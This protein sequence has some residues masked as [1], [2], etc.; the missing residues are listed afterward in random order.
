MNAPSDTRHTK[1]H[2]ELILNMRHPSKRLS[3][4][5]KRWRRA[6]VPH[7][8]NFFRSTVSVRQSAAQHFVAHRSKIVQPACQSIFHCLILACYSKL[9]ANQAEFMALTL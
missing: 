7:Q 6:I 4:H 9:I 2:P 8:K 3:R 1:V 5:R